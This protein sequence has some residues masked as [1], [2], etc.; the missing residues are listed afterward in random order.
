MIGLIGGILG[1]GIVRAT[2]GFSLCV[3][4]G[5][6]LGGEGREASGRAFPPEAWE[7]C[8]R[9]KPDGG[10]ARERDSGRLGGSGRKPR[11]KRRGWDRCAEKPGEPGRG[12][13]WWQAEKLEEEK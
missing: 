11:R 6:E 2:R 8:K 12:R 1:R 3:R 5:R 7:R 10:M 13:S 4:I 9:L